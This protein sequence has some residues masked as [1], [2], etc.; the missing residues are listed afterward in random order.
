[1]KRCELLAPAGSLEKLKIAI[2][3]GADAVY[4]G[5][6][7]FS[8]RVAADNFTPEEMREGIAFAHARVNGRA[9]LLPA[10]VLIDLIAPSVTVSD[11]RDLMRIQPGPRKVR[12]G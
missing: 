4:I 3:Y 11:E 9:A 12:G 10:V 6:E 7:E 8:L 5:G 1:M 2:L